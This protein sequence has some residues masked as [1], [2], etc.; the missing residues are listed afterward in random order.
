MQRLLPPLC[1]LMA[2]AMAVVGFGVWAVEAPQPS[3]ELHRA[4]ASG[5]E[6]YRDALEAQLR[7]QQLNRKILLACL[8]VG[9]GVFVAAAFLAMRPAESTGGR[10]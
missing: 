1:L 5:D 8:F 3:V 7:R 9:S 2:L 4:G 10:Q 6:Q